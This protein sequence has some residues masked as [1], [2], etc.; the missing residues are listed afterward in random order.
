MDSVVYTGLEPMIGHYKPDEFP[1]IW[2]AS[3]FSPSQWCHTVMCV[4]VCVCGGGGGGGGGNDCG[5]PF[6]FKNDIC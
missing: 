5:P 1:L 6:L 3:A 2:T 4:C